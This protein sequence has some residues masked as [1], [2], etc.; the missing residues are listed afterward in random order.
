MQLDHWGLEQSPFPTLLDADNAYPSAGHEEALNR[1]EYL[2]EARRRLGVVLGEPGV[3]KTLSLR[4]AAR[5]LTRKGHTVVMVS[6]LGLSSRELIW[7]IADGLR[8]APDK[9]ADVASLWRQVAAR[10]AESRLHQASAVLL[11][12]DAGQAGPDMLN[13][14]VRL[15]QLDPTP[16]ARWTIVLAAERDQT[17][18]WTQALR[19]LVDLRIDLQSWSEE[20]TIGFVQTAL[21]DAGR[22]D[23]IFD[24][25]ALAAMYELT[26]GVP[27]RV[28]QLANLALLAG[29]AAQ[30][31]TIDAAAIRE[32]HEEL[33]WPEAAIAY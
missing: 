28:A 25:E 1:I 19:E 20:D 16:A 26:D 24:D 11:H 7:Q 21:V 13:Q 33:R 27:R 22:F 32:A 17:G 5:R 23:P 3:G 8:A 18:R 2:V 10:V 4:A 14:F 9:D 15:A 31:E 30:L 12:D 6:G 29:A